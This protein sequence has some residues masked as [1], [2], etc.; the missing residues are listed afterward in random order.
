MAIHVVYAN[1]FKYTF[2]E[3]ETYNLYI[4]GEAY[5]DETQTLRKRKGRGNYCK[6]VKV[7]PDD[8]PTAV[9]QKTIV[10]QQHSPKKQSFIEGIKE[11]VVEG[12]KEAAKEIVKNTCCDAL[13][14]AKNKAL[15]ALKE[16]IAGQKEAKKELPKILEEVERKRSSSQLQSASKPKTKLK[17]KQ[18]SSEEKEHPE[19]QYKS[20]NVQQ[21]AVYHFILQL[22]AL[23]QRRDTGETELDDSIR[24]LTESGDLERFNH[25]MKADEDLISLSQSHRLEKLLGRSL[26]QNGNFIPIEAGEITK[27]FTLTVQEE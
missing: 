7:E 8:R 13:D 15:S 18:S 27:L 9:P 24:Q 16:F 4:S 14:Y 11:A 3:D 19:P 20:C 22:E 5:F 21:N 12:G 26:F 6:P 1:G 23:I 17:E 2:Y 25:T 10:V